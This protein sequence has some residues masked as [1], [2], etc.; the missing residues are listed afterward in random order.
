MVSIPGLDVLRTLADNSCDGA[1]KARAKNAPPFRLL[2]FRSI[3]TRRA[4]NQR[5][6]S[7]GS[8]GGGSAGLNGSANGA[9]RRIPVFGVALVTRWLVT[10]QSVRRKKV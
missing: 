6:A 3:V 10:R 5:N 7:G 4:S 9:R 1:G 2:P 8:F